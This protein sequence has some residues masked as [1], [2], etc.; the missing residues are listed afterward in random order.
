MRLNFLTDAHT[1]ESMV[2]PTVNESVGE[3]LRARPS[4]VTLDRPRVLRAHRRLAELEHEEGPLEPFHADNSIHVAVH[5]PR[6]AGWGS[7]ELAELATTFLAQSTELA[8][9]MTERAEARHDLLRLAFD[10]MLAVA[11][12]CGGGIERGFVSYRSHAEAFLTAW[13]EAAGRRAA[14][15]DHYRRHAGALMARVRAKLD[16][17]GPSQSATPTTRQPGKDTPVVTEAG[18]VTVRCYDSTVTT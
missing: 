5:Q 8:F 2:V 15:D 1:F 17:S 13:P 6:S 4:Q 12:R 16:A 11:H 9:A 7:S 18:T 10:L 14:W 3:Y